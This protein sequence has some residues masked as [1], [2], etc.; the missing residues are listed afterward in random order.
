MN[1]KDTIVEDSATLITTLEL[2]MAPKA[3]I[4]LKI[5]LASEKRETALATA[6]VMFALAI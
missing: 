6:G 5:P 2:L 4:K 3:K 1:L